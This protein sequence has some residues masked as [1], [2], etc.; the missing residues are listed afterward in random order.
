[1]RMLIVS[2]LGFLATRSCAYAAAVSG[3]PYRG[4]LLAFNPARGEIPVVNAITPGYVRFLD[5][6]GVQHFVG[7]KH[8]EPVQSRRISKEDYL[9]QLVKGSLNKDEAEIV[10][11]REE[12]FRLWSID[13][14]DQY[15]LETER[16]K[17]AG[18]EP[19][20]ELLSKIRTLEALIIAA[21]SGVNL[22]N[23]ETKQIREE[24]LRLWNE[25]RLASSQLD[26]GKTKQHTAIA[27]AAV[28]PGI[29]LRFQ[30]ADL[31]K[32]TPA[33]TAILGET[34]EQKKA[35]EEHLR[36]YKEQ[37]QHVQQ[38]QAEAAKLGE[39]SAHLSKEARA[40]HAA[41]EGRHQQEQG[42]QIVEHLGYVKE[43][44]EVLH[45]K[46]EHLRLWNEAKLR[47]EK[48]GYKYEKKQYQSEQYLTEGQYDT[49]SDAY[50]PEKSISEGKLSQKE[51]QSYDLEKQRNKYEDAQK[52]TYGQQLIDTHQGQKSDS[53]LPT[54]VRDTPEVQRARAEHLKI[55]EELQKKSEF[56]AD[57][58][59]ATKNI[60]DLAIH[61]PTSTQALQ[62]LQHHASNDQLGTTK[63][64]SDAGIYQSQPQPYAV[65]QETAEVQRAR[66]E[67]LKLVKEAHLKA[68]QSQT[69]S[70]Q[71]GIE[72]KPTL[73]AAPEIV[74]TP[75]ELK[76]E[77]ARL[78]IVE[79]KQR[80]AEILA[81]AGRI[82][83]EERLQTEEMLRLQQEEE[84]RQEQ[85]RLDQAKENKEAEHYAEKTQLPTL[86]QP[87]ETLEQLIKTQIQ[88]GGD[89]A[90]TYDIREKENYAANPYLLR[91]ATPAANQIGGA[92][93]AT[94]AYYIG[95]QNP[96]LQQQ[97]YLNPSY[98]YLRDASDSYIKLDNP[99]LLH[100]ITNKQDGKEQLA[101]A[102]AASLPSALTALNQVQKIEQPIGTAFAEKPLAAPI[103]PI[104]VAPA[105]PIL[106][107]GPLASSAATMKINY[108]ND[109][110][111]VALEQATRDH[112]R[113]HEIA[114]EQ[115]RLA[116]QKQPAQKD[117]Y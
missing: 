70:S 84:R 116:N 36:I 41:Q 31:A 113:A 8:T 23:P 108:G 76:D 16:L 34:A 47:A 50:K 42:V 83:E 103:I 71:I 96:A 75:G 12:H 92:P 114:L 88:R 65:V 52:S 7:Y 74:G 59:S 44:P 69:Q 26:S 101:T 78:R 35:R 81:E 86:E 4:E 54:P 67:H 79:T 64:I 22:E 6:Q 109:R 107:I 15:R 66:E 95:A 106:P 94:T 68:K 77:E 90:V 93:I 29:Y 99:Y 25:A 13:Q 19:S 111:L 85:E 3:Y 39:S 37:V 98:Y 87:K 32:D 115:L 14:Y 46:A 2:L 105:A 53:N 62:H 40:E 20:A 72:P 63:S 45:A 11:A 80:E 43:T 112:F 102:D 60:A 104:P 51:P 110:G 18:K 91:F 30:S 24:H 9:I 57:T 117:C 97:G 82:K 55:L 10:K 27:E 56:I 17:A 100:Y 89:A 21:R 28:K 61:Q 1:M 58:R 49:K 48:E 73:Y 33:Q 38:L 5:Q